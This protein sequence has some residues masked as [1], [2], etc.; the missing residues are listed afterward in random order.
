MKSTQSDLGAE[1]VDGKNKKKK[2]NKEKHAP[3]H[4]KKKEKKREGGTEK[5]WLRKVDHH[6]IR[7]ANTATQP[8]SQ[9][10]VQCL[11]K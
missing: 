6:S 1:S 7:K 5:Q 11:F 8:A 3:H 9:S 4:K 10:K 2:A